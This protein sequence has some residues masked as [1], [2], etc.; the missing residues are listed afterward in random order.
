MNRRRRCVRVSRR[1]AGTPVGARSGDWRSGSALRSHRRGHWFEPSIAHREQLPTARGRELSPSRRVL[2]ECSGGSGGSAPHD[3]HRTHRSRQHRQHR[4]AGWRSHAGHDV[5]LSNSRGPETLTDL[6]DELGDRAPGRRPGRGGRGRGDLVVVTIP[7]KN[8]RDVPVEPLRGK[9]VIDTNNYYPQRD[10]QIAELDDE[11]TTVS[12][13]LQAHLPES[14]VVK[15]FNNIYFQ[16][17]LALARPAGDPGPQRARDRRRRRRGE[18]AGGRAPRRASA[19]T[20]ST[21][22]RW[23]RA[24]ATSATRPPT[25][26]RTPRAGAPPTSPSAPAT[27]GVCASCSAQSRRYRDPAA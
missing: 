20:P 2:A 23:P 9:V 26:R 8:Y 3:H 16:H 13:L 4:R 27:P 1:T 10:G 14:H 5:V 21:P 18:A 22:V 15:A 12:E 24:G 7:L 25:A 17:L 6:V 11:S 19:T